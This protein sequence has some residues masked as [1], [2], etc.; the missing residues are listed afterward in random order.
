M[1]L[2]FRQMR[3]VHV[4]EPFASGVAHF[5]QSLV[6]NMPDDENIVIHG[7]RKSI[8]SADFVKREYFHQ[9]VKFIPWKS[10]QREINLKRDIRSLIDLYRILRLLK[11]KKTSV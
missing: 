9:N 5:V 8:L 3:I 6:E 11:K 2:E 10:A 4:I 7:E 1:T